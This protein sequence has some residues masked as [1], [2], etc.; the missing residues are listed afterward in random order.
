MPAVAAWKLE[1]ADKI[2]GRPTAASLPS[3]LPQRDRL[4]GEL[5]A[6]IAEDESTHLDHGGDLESKKKQETQTGTCNGYA[7]CSA[8]PLLSGN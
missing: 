1:C 2:K 6:F 3:A 8:R 7:R 5:D 4:S